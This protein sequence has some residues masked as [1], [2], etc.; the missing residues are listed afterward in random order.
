MSKKVKIYTDGGARGNPGPAG[1]GY[2]IYDESGE[3]IFRGKRFL[4]IN[5]NNFAEYMAIV[6]GLE[7]ALELGA[8]EVDAFLD[9]ELVVKQVNREYKVKNPELGK[10]FVKVFNLSNQFSRVSFSHVRREQ[11]NVADG[12]ANEAMDEGLA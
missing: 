7:K 2:V 8:N 4:G 9:S 10:L 5:T 11:N 3:V 12:L 6:L 1:A